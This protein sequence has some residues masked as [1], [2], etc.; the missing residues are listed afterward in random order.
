[1]YCKTCG[2]VIPDG[3]NYCSQC[4]EPVPSVGMIEAG[5]LFFKNYANFR[6]R[7]RRSEY[8]KASIF[9]GLI[10]GLISGLIFGLSFLSIE[11]VLFMSIVGFIWSFAI[12]I[13]SFSIQIRR[14]H[15][16]G[17]NGWYLLFY[18]IPLV[19]SIMLLIWMC[20]DSKED[21]EWG[22]NPKYRPIRRP[23]PKAQPAPAARPA[24]IPGDIPLTA[25]PTSAQRLP[26]T[27]AIPAPS[28]QPAVSAFSATLILCTGPMAGK[29]FTYRAGERVV[30][31]RSSSANAVLNGYDK[32]SGTH[33]RVEIGSNSVTV[34]D[35]GSTNGTKV[36]GQR[37]S[38]NAPVKVPHGGVIILADNNCAFQVKYN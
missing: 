31:G 37:L 9:C 15:D 24:S 32:V 4:A 29:Q 25:L 22:P 2:K 17:Y 5:K 13:P 11:I 18:L 34:T 35:L 26:D 6:G 20:T 16:I 28:V 36:G 21:N 23:M 1:M 30:F 14:L 38:P 19:G 8:W 3:T 33:C 27:P 7:A 10:S 12:L